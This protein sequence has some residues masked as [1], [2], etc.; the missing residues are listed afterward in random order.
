L[1][2]LNNDICNG[3]RVFAYSII[4]PISKLRAAENLLP[5]NLIHLTTQMVAAQHKSLLVNNFHHESGR[6]FL[7]SS[8]ASAAPVSLL[9][10]AADFN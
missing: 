1:A 3:V 8:F 10:E 4:A 5:F 7:I 9:L 2:K 6:L